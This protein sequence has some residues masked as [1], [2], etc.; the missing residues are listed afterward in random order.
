MIPNQ[1]RNNESQSGAGAVTLHFAQ[2]SQVE[3]SSGRARVQVQELGMESYWLPVLQY[4]A[5]SSSAY[6]MP[7]AGEM[8]AA[9]LDERGEGGCILG[10]IYTGT[11]APP[12]DGADL[13]DVRTE[14]IVIQ[15]NLTITGD[16]E[17]NGVTSMNSSGNNI[18]GSDICVIGGLDSAGHTNVS[19]GQ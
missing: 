10:G 19:S 7:N 11:N 5:G 6:W 14:E 18:N 13:L 9:L 16:V 15:G 4:R 8:V 17:I 2:V 12:A 3:L 1:Q